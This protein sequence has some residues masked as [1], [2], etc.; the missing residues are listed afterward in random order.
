ML[1]T[2]DKKMGNFFSKRYCTGSLRGQKVCR[3]MLFLA[4]V[5]VFMNLRMHLNC[6]NN[7]WKFA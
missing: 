2:A 4:C 3:K 1:F 7:S 5:Y 6:F